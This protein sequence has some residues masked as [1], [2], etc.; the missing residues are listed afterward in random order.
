MINRLVL[1]EDGGLAFYARLGS[2]TVGMILIWEK[3]I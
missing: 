3:C 2:V 1:I